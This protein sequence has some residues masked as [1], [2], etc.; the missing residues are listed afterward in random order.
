M[1]NHLALSVQVEPMTTCS[2]LV[3]ALAPL[4]LPGIFKLI[5]NCAAREEEYKH[6]ISELEDTRCQL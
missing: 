5:L 4:F 6:Q 2:Q 1:S 3:L